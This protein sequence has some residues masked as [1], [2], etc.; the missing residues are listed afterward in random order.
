[1]SSNA[2]VLWILE[3]RK[4]YGGESISIK[5]STIKYRSIVANNQL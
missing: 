5:F 4:L 3:S 2:W 1:M